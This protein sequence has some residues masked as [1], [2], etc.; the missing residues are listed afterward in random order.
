MNIKLHIE[1]IPWKIAILNKSY[2]VDLELSLCSSC[3]IFS[4][5]D[6]LSSIDW[7]LSVLDPILIS[8]WILV[9]P[10]LCN[11]VCAWPITFMTS[12]QLPSSVVPAECIEY[13]IPLAA[14]NFCTF[15]MWWETD[16]VG[17]AIGIK[18]KS[19]VTCSGTVRWAICRNETFSVP[20]EDSW[21][22]PAMLEILYSD[23]VYV[24]VNCETGCE[25]RFELLLRLRL[26][27]AASATL[28]SRDGFDSDCFLFSNRRS[29]L[30]LGFER[31]GEVG[32]DPINL[33]ILFHKM[34][35]YEKRS[36]C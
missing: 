3:S 28:F 34:F 10:W 25:V 2:S 22:K 23:A 27:L 17:V 32:F 5:A 21:A 18:Q 20:C 31:F 8:V 11:I 35:K 29:E 12:S 15:A 24:Y 19:A 1:M 13:L 9:T 33:D 4:T 30:V 14:S 7:V 6:T 26:C 16:A 36:L